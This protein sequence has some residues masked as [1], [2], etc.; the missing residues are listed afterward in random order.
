MFSLYIYVYS[1]L[2]RL[3]KKVEF[4]DQHEFNKKKDYIDCIVFQC[5]T[6]S[7]AKGCLHRE[8]EDRRTI[9]M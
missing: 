3:V 4:L 1:L 7:K 6:L 8:K 2:S 5:Q 9:S